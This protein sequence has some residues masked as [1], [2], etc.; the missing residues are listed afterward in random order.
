MHALLYFIEPTALGVKKFDIDF[1]KKLAGRVNIIPVIAKA[2]GLTDEE[3]GFFKK[4]VCSILSKN[5]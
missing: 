4:K 1:M 5:D 2:D 3:K